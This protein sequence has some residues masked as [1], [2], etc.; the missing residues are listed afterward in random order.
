[1]LVKCIL[2]GQKQEISKIHKDYQRLASNPNGPYTCFKCNN[3]VKISASKE[4]KTNKK[5]L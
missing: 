3:N 5:L 1:M 4:I 2:C